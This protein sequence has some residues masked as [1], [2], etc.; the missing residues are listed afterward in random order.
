LISKLRYR[1][2]I[3]AV[4]LIGLAGVGAQAAQADFII[5]FNN[6]KVGGTLG[7]K[8]LNQ[9]IN[10]PP[11]STFNGS[12][13][14]NQGTLTGHTRI[15]DFDAPL[16]VLGIPTKASLSITEAAPTAGTLTGNPDG[17]VTTDATVSSI[18]RI[19]KLSIGVLG[20]PPGA[21][22]HSASPVVL[23]LR[24]V[25]ELG[26]IPINGTQFSGT[27]TITKFTGCGLLTPVINTVMAGPNNPFTVSL[28]PQFAP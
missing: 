11:G 28:K 19:R 6:W 2:G 23:P 4:A 5:T 25:D 13:N 18:I 12:A 16:T 26:S 10:L 24:G 21:N 20:I 9:S 7:V 1:F 17:T 27:Y 3:L 15:P 22:C 14:L 8:K